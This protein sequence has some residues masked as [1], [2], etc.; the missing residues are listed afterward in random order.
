M[1]GFT[2]KAR[3]QISQTKTTQN[4]A[5]I[6]KEKSSNKATQ[7]PFGI[8]NI[9]VTQILNQ[10]QLSNLNTSKQTTGRSQSSLISKSQSTTLLSSSTLKLTTPK[11]ISLP[12]STNSPSKQAYKTQAILPNKYQPQAI[13]R[14]TIPT[15]FQPFLCNQ[16]S[17]PNS[18]HQHTE[19]DL[20]SVPSSPTKLSHFCAIVLRRV[21]QSCK[22][23]TIQNAHYFITRFFDFVADKA[24]SSYTCTDFILA[25]S[26]MQSS[27]LSPKT[28]Q[29]LLVYPSL[30]IKLAIAQGLIHVSPLRLAPKPKIRPKP[31]IA[32]SKADISLL[33][34]HATG[35]LKLFLYIAFFSGA[36]SGEILALHSS[37]IHKGYISITKNQTRLGL[38]SPKNGLNRVVFIPASL[39]RY[40]QKLDLDGEIFK[41]DYFHIYYEFRK[42]LSR[43]NFPKCGLHI[44]RHTYTS[45]LMKAGADPT[46]IQR[47]LGHSSLEMIHRVYAHHIP[48]PKDIKTINSCFKI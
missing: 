42:L 19:L 8:Q 11:S 15:S 29:N 6:S 14:T 45:L 2:Q 10:F 39:Q 13:S 36:R 30:A 31:K 33:L 22:L 3:T 26:G 9:N 32:F 17:Q 5:K 34:R 16:T 37:D 23:T 38:S 21:A 4:L 40:L 25:I 43:L 12:N 1:W 41:S 27:R 24:V 20:I 47:N 46:L 28:I 44:T 18:P 35:E 48:D 7:I